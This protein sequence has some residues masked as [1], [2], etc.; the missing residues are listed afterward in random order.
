MRKLLIIMLLAFFATTAI[1]QNGTV[2]EPRLDAQ[3][4]NG[5]LQSYFVDTATAQNIYGIKTFFANPIISNA[6]PQLSVKDS[7]ATAGDVNAT[8]KVTATDTGDGTEDIDVQLEQQV[9]G[10]LA[11]WIFSDADQGIYLYPLGEIT[12][13]VSV[14]TGGDLNMGA[15]GADDIQPTFNIWG[16]ADSD[17]G[18]DTDE[19]LSITLTPSVTPTSATWG[20]ASTQSSGYTFDKAVKPSANDG[21][22]LGVTGTGWADFFLASGGVIDFNSGDVTL[23][24]SS[25]LLTITGGNTRVDRLEIDGANDWID[26]ATDMFVTSAADI[27]LDPQGN[28]VIVTGDLVVN[29]GYVKI[30]G[31]KQATNL[32]EAINDDNGSVGD[33]SVVITATGNVGIGTTS[34]TGKFTIDGNK[35]SINLLE[36]INDDDGAVGDSSFVITKLGGFTANGVSDVVGAFTAGTIASD[37]GVSGTTGSFTSDVTMDNTGTTVNSPI[38]YLRGDA[39]GTEQEATIQLIQGANEYLRISV[40][41]ASE[42]LQPVMDI[43]SDLISLFNGGAGIDYYLSFNGETNDGTITYMEDEDRFDFDNDVKAGG[44]IQAVGNLV[45]ATYNFAADAEASDTY[46]ITLSPAPAAYTTGMMI[47]FTAN[48]ANTDGATINVNGLGAKAILKMHDQA[49][50]TGDIEAGQVVVGVYDGTQFQMT[51]QLA[52]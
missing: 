11:R 52:Q 26:I 48:T 45:S 30:D 31:N 10:T 37:A 24:H 34:P 40:D 23:T 49:L 16:D 39:S 9:A 5:Y 7:D 2:I 46:V 47:V 22:A 25:N 21:A 17:A 15:T 28:D 41:D 35:G 32:F 3:S 29:G 6:T 42:S 12:S 27:I 33:S 13:P 20:F 14:T 44:T 50:V 4:F 19:T 38:L 51:S 36:A 18:D 1:G 8:F 43:R